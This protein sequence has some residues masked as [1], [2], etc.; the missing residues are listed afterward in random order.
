MAC[1]KVVTAYLPGMHEY[2]RQNKL[3]DSRDTNPALSETE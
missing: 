3:P 1:T 2:L